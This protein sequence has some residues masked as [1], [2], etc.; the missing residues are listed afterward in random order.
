MYHQWITPDEFA[1]RFGPTDADFGAVNNWLSANGFQVIGG[2]REEGYLR[3]SSDTAAAERAFNTQLEDFGDGKF[4][5]LTEPE[6]PAQFADVIGD[7]LGMQ[8]LG[9]LQP[10]YATSRLKQDARKLAASKRAAHIG[11]A[12]G[13]DFNLNSLGL[14]GFTFAAPDL[15]NF[16]DENPLLSGGNTGANGSH[17]IGIFANTNIYPEPSQAS[18]LSD[19]FSFFSPFTS[20]STDPA[21]TIDL[22][23]ESNPG[24]IGNSTDIEAYLDIEAAHV[25]AWRTNN[26]VRHQSKA[27]VRT[28]SERRDHRDDH[29]EQVQRAQ[30]QLPHLRRD[31][32]FPDH[33]AGRSF[34]K[35]ADQRERARPP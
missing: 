2:S 35:S 9:R 26:R 11:P 31:T 5:N 28:E 22:S 17:C 32:G 7:I 8:N 4:A 12:S 33:H 24:V 27:F 16:Y 14:L 23:N 34:L 25:I 20:F 13:A 15:Y 3:F 30:F 18:I 29:R 10:G 19:Y 21:L 6:I 1:H